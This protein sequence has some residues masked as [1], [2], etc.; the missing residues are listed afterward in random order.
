MALIYNNWNANIIDV[1]A[2]QI[3]TDDTNNTESFVELSPYQNYGIQCAWSDVVGTQP[4]FKLQASVDS[5]NWE[6]IPGANQVTTGASGSVTF[7][8]ANFV[9]NQIRALIT[10]ASTSGKLDVRLLANG[11]DGKGRLKR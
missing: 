6:D 2:P 7:Q 1:S 8:I 5:V 4:E 3:D 11:A 10:T 9:T